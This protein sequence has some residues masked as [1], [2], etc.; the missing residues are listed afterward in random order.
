MNQPS[1]SF[2]KHLLVALF[3]FFSFLTFAQSPIEGTPHILLPARTVWP[4]GKKQ[5]LQIPYLGTRPTDWKI[6]RLPAGFHLDAEKGIISGQASSRAIFEVEVIASNS[7][8]ADSCLWQIEVSRLNGAAPIMGWS[9]RWLKESDINEQTILAVAESM[10]KSGL[11]AAGYTHIIIESRW[12]TA[13][14]DSEGH[15]QADPKRFPRGIKYLADELHHRGMKLGLSSNASPLNVHDL[16]GS[17]EKEVADAATFSR[18]GIDYLKYDYCCAPPIS[19]VAQQRYGAMGR[20]LAAMDHPI[21]FAMCEWGELLPWSWGPAVRAGSW[22]TTFDIQDKWKASRYNKR[23]NGILDAAEINLRYASYANHTHLVS[24]PDILLLGSPS[25][26]CTFEEYY[27]QLQMWAMM[28]APL[29]FAADPRSLS[30]E[31]I[32]LLINP[33]LLA[34]NQDASFDNIVETKPDEG[35]RL[36]TRKLTKGIAVLVLNTGSDAVLTHIDPYPSYTS[37]WD[38]SRAIY[39][40]P[41]DLERIALPAHAARLFI[42]E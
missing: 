1:V 14:R 35:I 5:I 25:G 2:R 42:F 36:W 37:V 10:Q 38:A 18:W 30:S 21:F 39:V 22:R 4:L 41:R 12:Q 9:T 31:V 29:I 15:I 33:D 11:V 6:K 23:D 34:I 27:S 3:V 7:L 17:F 19:I 32:S 40:A 20:A 13:K 28:R 8:G 26:G 24:D 16:S